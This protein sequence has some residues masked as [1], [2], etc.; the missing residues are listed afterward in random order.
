[1]ASTPFW[2]E[3]AYPFRVYAALNKQP[4]EKILDLREKSG[5]I[6]RRESPFLSPVYRRKSRGRGEETTGIELSYRGE[7]G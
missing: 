6:P 2:E 4:I 7:N 3:A 1:V 5:E